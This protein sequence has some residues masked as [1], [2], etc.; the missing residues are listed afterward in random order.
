MWPITI[1]GF[2]AVLIIV[3]R[4]IVLRRA[5]TR[6][7]EF[8]QKVRSLVL[9]GQIRPAAEVCDEYRGV[10]PR[11]FKVALLGHEQ[12]LSGDALGRTVENAAIYEVMRLE[13]HLWMVAL[14][15]S[16]APILGFLGTVVGMIMSFDVIAKE[17]MNNPGAVAEGISVALIT[18]AGGLIVATYA[19]PS[20][21]WCM[22]RIGSIQHDI[23]MAVNFL[24]QALSEAAERRSAK[25]S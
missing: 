21:N 20:Y 9:E 10:I 18:T 24:F 4:V 13:K 12:G 1:L 22:Q 7:N 5:Q 23:E 11:V 25:R 8:T 17:G 6:T 16:L 14:I 2:I 3:E 15:T 19:Q